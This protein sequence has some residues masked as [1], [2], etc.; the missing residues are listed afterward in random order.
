MDKVYIVNTNWA[1][2]DGSSYESFDKVFKSYD[3]AFKFYKEQ[4]K[5]AKEDMSYAFNK[6]GSDAEGYES[7]E[8][9]PLEGSSAYF[10]VWAIGDY[11]GDH[12]E[13]S[14]QCHIVY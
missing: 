4:V 14:I 11:N 9:T 13:V 10:S 1:T 7:D 6:D 2:D 5:S 8:Y 12:Y 3:D